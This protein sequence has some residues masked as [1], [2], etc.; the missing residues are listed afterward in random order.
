MVIE[1]IKD[2]LE[3][4]FESYRYNVQLPDRLFVGGFS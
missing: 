3:E 2:E 4:T 1:I